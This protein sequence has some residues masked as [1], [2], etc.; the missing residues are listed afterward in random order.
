MES[1]WPTR[2]KSHYVTE[3][4]SWLGLADV[5]FRRNQVTAGNTSAF[6]GYYSVYYPSN[7]SCNTHSFENWRIFWDIPQLQLWNVRSR[8]AFRPIARERK[9]LMDYKTWQ[10]TRL[11]HCSC[12]NSCWY[13]RAGSLIIRWRDTNEVSVTRLAI[14]VIQ[15]INREKSCHLQINCNPPWKF[16]HLSK[17]ANVVWFYR[18]F[19][20]VSRHW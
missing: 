4:V 7:I 15:D 11:A 14:Q 17:A 20:K 10:Q 18:K 9:Y 16:V 19:N 5:I 13:A 12:N 1:D 8:D 6:A 3:N 2:N